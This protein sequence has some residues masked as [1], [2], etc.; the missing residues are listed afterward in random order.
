MKIF[1]NA[2]A[3][4]KIIG[5]VKKFN[6]KKNLIL[7]ARKSG[8]YEK[9]RE[10]LGYYT[11][12]WVKGLIEDLD[13]TLLVKG[14]ENIPEGPCVFIS[15]HQSYCDVFAIISGLNGKPA[16]FIAKEDLKKVPY[17]GKWIEIIRGLF[18]PRG[19]PRESIKVIK[20]GAQY[21]KDGFSMVIFPEGKRSKC[22]QMNSF[23]PGSFK[24]ATMASVPIVPIA[25]DGGYKAFEETGKYTPGQ[26]I[27][28]VICE[29]VET[30]GLDRNQLKEIPRQVESIIGETLK[31]I[32]SDDITFENKIKEEQNDN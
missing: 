21:I 15:N 4:L 27:K 3:A 24:L 23:K 11:D 12:I 6:S 8:D 29:P 31:N 10:I 32:Q 22:G 30:K 9:E 26:T 5:S 17:F 20:Q 19:N 25:V 7:D 14:Q 16:G 2:N 13:I 18:I 28:M 1:A